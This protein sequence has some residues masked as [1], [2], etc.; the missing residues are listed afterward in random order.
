MLAEEADA[1][2]MKITKPRRRAVEP[3]GTTSRR[4]RVLHHFLGLSQARTR[5]YKVQAL[6][7][8]EPM[9]ERSVCREPNGSGARR[10]VQRRPPASSSSLSRGR[11]S[12]HALREKFPHDVD[13]SMN[14]DDLPW[15]GAADSRSYG[16]S[17]WCTAHV[18]RRRR[19]ARPAA[20][21]TS[22]FARPSFA[23]RA[24]RGSRRDPG[25]T[26]AAFGPRQRRPRALETAGWQS[27]APA[28]RVSCAGAGAAAE[29]A[30]SKAHGCA[31]Q[32]AALSRA[33]SGPEP[34]KGCFA[35]VFTQ[36]LASA[37]ESQH[38]AAGGRARRSPL[39][40]LAAKSDPK[41]D[42]PTSTL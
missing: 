39:C 12:A 2:M 23:P 20:A 27:R 37:C 4:R 30:F 26:A 10:I 15:F 19:A 11:A 13:G 28:R 9:L 35:S 36:L 5:L 34:A 32:R 40:W 31:S 29:G 7:L 33:R 42:L 25:G 14:P 1:S 41:N 21:P 6:H 8:F 38:T 17:G 22:A 18:S 3:P 16:A 24:G